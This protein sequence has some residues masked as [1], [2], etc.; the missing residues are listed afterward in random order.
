M[1]EGFQLVVLS[2]AH[3]EAD[4]EAVRASASS[5]RNTFGLHNDWPAADLSFEQNRADLVRHEAEF[6]RR[7]AFA[8]A[9]LDPR[10]AQYLGCVYIKPIKS[11]LAEDGRK[12][13]FQAQVFFWL[14]VGTTEPSAGQVLAELNR[15]LQQDWPFKA[16]AFPGRVQ[17]WSDWEAL[18]FADL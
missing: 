4:F 12:K 8:Y 18:A 7:Q 9:L 5:I 10:G 2:P 17:L 1:A 16:V 6:E 13:R 14:S 11:K 15:W 3:A